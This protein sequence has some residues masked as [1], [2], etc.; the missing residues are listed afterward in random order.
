M[1]ETEAPPVSPCVN[2]C[3]LDANG[4]CRGCYRTIEEIAR[5]QGMSHPEQR[6]LLCALGERASASGRK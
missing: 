2:I 5:W 3:T 4:Y 1:F 6:A